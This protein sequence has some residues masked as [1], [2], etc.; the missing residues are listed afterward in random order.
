MVITMY[1][2]RKKS[3]NHASLPLT[4]T[5]LIGST[6]GKS[7]PLPGRRLRQPLHIN[8]SSGLLS[9]HSTPHPYVASMLGGG[10]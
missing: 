1:M 2:N 3:H 7:F 8:K 10:H 6:V 9:D 4:T 5:F